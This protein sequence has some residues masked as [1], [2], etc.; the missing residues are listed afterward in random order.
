V[1]WGWA[2]WSSDEAVALVQRILRPIL[3]WDPDDINVIVEEQMPPIPT[4]TNLPTERYVFEVER[5]YDWSALVFSMA[6]EGVPVSALN[7]TA[8]KT[9]LEQARLVLGMSPAMDA[10]YDDYDAL[11]VYR[12]YDEATRLNPAWHEDDDDDESDGDDIDV[13]HVVPITYAAHLMFARHYEGMSD[14]L[15]AVMG[16][17]G[18]AVSIVDVEMSDDEY[19]RVVDLVAE[20]RDGGDEIDSLIARDF[21]ERLEAREHDPRANPGDGS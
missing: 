1:R 8:A 9:A 16:R 21:F 7:L 20:L 6:A 11:D 14:P 3:S 12:V 17:R 10:A 4:P 2:P 19:E 13:W 18:N 5:A 15:Y